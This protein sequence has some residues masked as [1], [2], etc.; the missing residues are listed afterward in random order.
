METRTETMDKLIQKQKI[1]ALLLSGKEREYVTYLEIKS[2]L[3]ANSLDQGQ[4]ES[5]ASTFRDMNI[6]VI[7]K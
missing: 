2:C 4:I 5:I 1:S 7:A 6:E 3:P